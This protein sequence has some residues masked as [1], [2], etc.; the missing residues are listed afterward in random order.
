LT[1]TVQY[2]THELAGEMPG[3]TTS[4]LYVS[5][6]RGSA[7]CA[8][9]PTSY[10][11]PLVDAET[12]QVPAPVAADQPGTATFQATLPPGVYSLCAYMLQTFPFVDNTPEIRA[13]AFGASAATTT[14]LAATPS[15]SSLIT[16]SPGVHS[17]SMRRS[18]TTVRG[19]DMVAVVAETGSSCKVARKIVLKLIRKIDVTGAHSARSERVLKVVVAG[20][21]FVCHVHEPTGSQYSAACDRGHAVVYVKVTSHGTIGRRK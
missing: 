18:C 2:A 20:D 5:A 19:T 1:A 8:S 11:Q 13:P 9:P 6:S 17:E 7:G 4:P 10:Q 12:Q 15:A 21:S 14:V 3:T 16:S